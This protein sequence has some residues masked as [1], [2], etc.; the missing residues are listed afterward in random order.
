MPILDPSQY[1]P[2]KL[3]QHRH[4]ATMA[5]YF[6]RKSDQ[7]PYIR[8]RVDTPDGD[9]V[10]VDRITHGNKR[11]A[12]LCHGLEGD[13]QSKYVVGQG[14]QLIRNHWDIAAMN[15]RG[16]S[17][18]MN[19]KLQMYHSGKTEDLQTVID[20]VEPDY[21]HIVL[22]GYSLGG[23]LVIKYTGEQNPHKT[24]KL[25][26]TVGISV[27]VDLSACSNAFSRRENYFYEKRFMVTLKQKVKLK[28]KV[29]PD[30]ID[31]EPLQKMKSIYEF[32][33][34]YT[35][36]IHGFKDAEDYY[37]QNNCKQFLGDID[38]PTLIL[39]S[40]D[41]PFLH[42]DCF[43]FSEAEDSAFVHLLATDYGGHV[44]FAL[45]LQRRYFSE[46]KTL[47]FINQYL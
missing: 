42:P 34:A 32:D 30:K 6:L 33:D 13:S 20:Y 21:D 25:R 23:N 12:I 22:I 46:E 18:E 19:R 37:A 17:G 41:D 1:I 3:L 4:I 28:H 5:P 24:T 35:A 7:L 31:L 16:C 15:Y 10:D 40:K 29:F 45:D 43:P 9:F 39:N 44:G 8:E 27:P 47:E 14:A 11:I 36:P 26:A 38:I 2:R